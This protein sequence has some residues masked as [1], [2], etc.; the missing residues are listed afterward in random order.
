M[1]LT[2]RCVLAGLTSA[3]LNGAPRVE[4]AG[5]AWI[6]IHMHVLGGADRQFGPP[7]ER[8]VAEMDRRGIAKAVIF[9]PPFPRPGPDYPAYAG[10]LARYPGRFGFLAG[11]GLLNPMI[12]GVPQPA[13]VTPQVR[14][15]FVDAARRALDAGAVGFGEIAI[16]HLSLTPNHSFEQVA[17]DHPLL[18]ALAEVTGERGAVID[19]HMDP[20]PGDGDTRTPAP[21][22]RPANPSTLRGNVAAFERLLA[23]ERK[24]RIV[25][26]HGGSD[27]LGH[28]S[29]ALIRRLMDSHPNLCMSLRPVPADLTFSKAVGLQ[30][31][32][33]MLHGSGIVSAWLDVMK[34]HSDRFVLGADTFHLSASV[35]SNAG[36]VTLSRGNEARFTGAAQLLARLPADLAR[37]I[38]Q[39][40]AKRLYRL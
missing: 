10:E 30:L 23:H 26:A 15:R 17:A 4:A 31:H 25:W 16:L 28:M 20:V 37:R 19:L 29:P 5:P 34:R 8:A 13:D 39:E 27:P 1:V 3:T 7:L 40:N 12:H 32:N 35:P 38:G 33:T 21:L 2:R 9:P 18:L 14:Q 36:V 22:N 11:G 24:A 6:D